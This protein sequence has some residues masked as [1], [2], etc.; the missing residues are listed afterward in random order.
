MKTKNL[1]RLLT[2]LLCAALFLTLLSACSTKPAV[3]TAP[4]VLQD[5]DALGTG[6]TAFTLVIV[7]KEGAT[8]TVDVRTDEA[9]VGAALLAHNIIAGETSDYGLYV[10]TVNGITADYDTDKT[11]WGFYID[12]EY[13]MT[14]VDAT[15]IVAGTTYTL[16]VE[17]G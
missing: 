14:G 12:G 3:E 15:E 13:A 9:T 2:L 8:T 5:G 4:S 16:R 11:Y 6:K 17:Q 1:N 10:K 7:D